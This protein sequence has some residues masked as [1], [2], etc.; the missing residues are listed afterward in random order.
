MWG[1]RGLLPSERYCDRFIPTHV[2][3]AI[4]GGINGG[5]GAVH[6]HAC[7]ERINQQTISDASTRFIPTHVGNA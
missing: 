5:V 1:T 4:G 2:G 6:P 7:G 3:N